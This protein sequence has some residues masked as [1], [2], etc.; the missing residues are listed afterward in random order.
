MEETGMDKLFIEQ[1][2]E[3]FISLTDD[4][5]VLI[6]NIYHKCFTKLL[7]LN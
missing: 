5:S 7:A 2:L 6:Y 4:A 3:H 1:I